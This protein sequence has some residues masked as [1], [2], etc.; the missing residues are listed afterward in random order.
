MEFNVKK[1]EQLRVTNKRC[2]IIH[3]YF[4][5]NSAITEAQ[6]TK[7]F[8]VTIGQKLSW[9]E[10]TQRITSKENQVNGFLHCN[11]HQCPYKMMA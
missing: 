4:L 3:S 2:P 5:E 7:Y 11:L 10:H 1:C 9:N 6:H 8:G